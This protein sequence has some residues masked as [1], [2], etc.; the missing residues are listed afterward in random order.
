MNAQN[1]LKHAELSS[2]ISSYLRK[3]KK[4]AAEVRTSTSKPLTGYLYLTTKVG[5]TKGHNPHG[6]SCMHV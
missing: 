3:E 1:I 4:Y 5:G 6:L 2:K